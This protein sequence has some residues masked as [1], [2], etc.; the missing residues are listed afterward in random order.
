MLRGTPKPTAV[1]GTPDREAMMG[2]GGHRRSCLRCVVH[3]RWA[4]PWRPR[5]PL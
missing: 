1:S 2:Q 5:R 4:M 3:K